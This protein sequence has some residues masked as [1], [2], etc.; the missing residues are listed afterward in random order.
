MAGHGAA[1]LMPEPLAVAVQRFKQCA[2]AV[3]V[4]LRRSTPDPVMRRDLT[5]AFDTLVRLTGRLFPPL[6]GETKAPDSPA[7]RHCASKCCPMC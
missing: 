5:A 7:F 6:S 4:D 2:A 3:E 1:S